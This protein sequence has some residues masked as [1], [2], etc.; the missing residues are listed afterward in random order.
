[1]RTF[2]FLDKDKR[3]IS[4]QLRAYCRKYHKEDYYALEGPLNYCCEAY[5]VHIQNRVVFISEVRVSDRLQKRHYKSTLAL[6]ALS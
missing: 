1:M 2:K 4:T 6:S 3:E 5:P